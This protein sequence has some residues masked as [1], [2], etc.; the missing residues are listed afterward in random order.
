MIK[1]KKIPKLPQPIHH[2]IFKNMR[3][4][5]LKMALNALQ[6]MIIKLTRIYLKVKWN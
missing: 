2:K 1:S 4:Q 3:S 6:V 5:M